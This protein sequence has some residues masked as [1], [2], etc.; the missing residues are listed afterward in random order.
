MK[1]G[2]TGNVEFF[3]TLTLTSALQ[4][5]CKLHLRAVNNFDGGTRVKGTC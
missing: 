5:F 1:G 2:S 3:V 4:L